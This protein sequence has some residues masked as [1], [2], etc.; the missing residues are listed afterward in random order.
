MVV[1]KKNMAVFIGIL[2]F[3]INFVEIASAARPIKRRSYGD[4]TKVVCGPPR[5]SI[6]FEL[7]DDAQKYASWYNTVYPCKSLRKAKHSIN[8][9][10]V[11][12][13]FDVNTSQNVKGDK[14]PHIVDN[15]SQE[16]KGDK[17]HHIVDTISQEIKGDKDHHLIILPQPSIV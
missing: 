5:R 16:I 8:R 3:S 4:N 13:T 9:D 6:D 2:L 11:G 7:D 12:N 10:K 15:T 14:D 1:S 17:D